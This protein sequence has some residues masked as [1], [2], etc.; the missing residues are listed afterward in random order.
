ASSQPTLT[1]PSSQSVSP[2]GT[3]QLPC[4]ISSNRDTIYWYQQ[5][6]G[7]PPRFILYGTSSRGPGIP[8]RFTGS[9]SGNLEHLTITSVR[10]EDDGVYYCAMWYGNT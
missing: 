2:G 4:T 6:E 8:D 9:S 1:Q 7:S 10:E 5:R 3:P